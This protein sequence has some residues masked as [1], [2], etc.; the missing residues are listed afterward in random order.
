MLRFV[1]LPPETPEKREAAA[2]REDF[3]EIYAGYAAQ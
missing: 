2:R 1:S 3:D